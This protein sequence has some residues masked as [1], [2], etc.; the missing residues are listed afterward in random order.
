M[1][2][3]VEISNT[4]IRSLYFLERKFSVD[5]DFVNIFAKK[6]IFKKFHTYIYKE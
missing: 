2:T 4:T 5:Y 1:Q 3:F 6:C